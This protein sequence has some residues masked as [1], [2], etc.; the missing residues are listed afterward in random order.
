MKTITHSNDER[1]QVVYA[2]E[3]SHF[4]GGDQ[5]LSDLQAGFVTVQIT[6]GSEEN[7]TTVP[8]RIGVEER[9]DI[10]ELD[11]PLPDSVGGGNRSG[12][13]VVGYSVSMPSAPED[14]ILDSITLQCE[15]DH[16][17]QA[18]IQLVEDGDEVTEETV[19]NTGVF[20]PV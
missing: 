18:E 3:Q 17:Y 12:I 16:H 11:E 10:A 14:V 5:L 1:R 7:A 15:N 8:E 20:T 6:L 4:D 13:A 2:Q 9:L 19:L